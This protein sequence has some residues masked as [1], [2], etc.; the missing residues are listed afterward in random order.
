[1]VESRRALVIFAAM[2]MIVVGADTESGRR[3]LEGIDGP[4]REIRV[5]VTDPD[6]AA[7]YK[8]RGFKVALGDVS[9]DSHVEAAATRCFSA[10]LIAEAAGDER[11]RSFA[12]NAHEVLIGWAEAVSRSSVRRV[13]WVSGE[14]PPRT[15][16]DEVAVVDPTL[17]DLADQVVALDDAHSIG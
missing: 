3:I 8:A 4:E 7:D 11:E 13:I 2:P 15:R 12:E 10:V 6:Q 5:F 17:P 14:E 1:M 9:D 16:V